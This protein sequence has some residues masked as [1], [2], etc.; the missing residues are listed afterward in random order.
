MRVLERIELIDRIGRELQSRMTFADIAIYLGAY[1]VKTKDIQPSSNSKW[2]YVKELLA[3]CDES[4]ISS[5]ADELEL[6]HNFSS[7]VP[8]EATF[9][10]SGHFKLFLSH[11]ASFKS[12]TA[13]LQQV[14]KKY[15]ITSFVAHEDIQPTKEWQIEIESALHT[16][17]A[18]VAILMD[19]FKE[20]NWCDQEVGFAVGK[21]VLIIPVRK[22]LDPYGFIGKYQGIQA[23]G[24]N[25][26]QVAEEIFQTIVKSTKTRGKMLNSLANA[27]TQSIE[28]G[29]ATEKVFLLQSVQNIPLEILENIKK[30]ATENTIL[31]NSQIFV[32]ALNELFSEYS[33]EKLNL[34][35]EAVA[36]QWNDDVPF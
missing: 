21:N 3:D 11:L 22:G 35:G 36:T 10:K 31:I 13:K 9:W 4:L 24:K 6:N 1:G 34:G 18:M 7:N 29:E 19:G 8:K 5:I 14:L 17:D 27:I 33:I 23:N 32:N 2:V 30:S 20:S 25:V 28:V 12:N 16:M 26:G 15:A